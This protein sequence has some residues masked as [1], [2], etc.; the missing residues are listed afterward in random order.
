MNTNE[1]YLSDKAVMNILKALTTEV[2]IHG[3]DESELVM[4]SELSDSQKQT[5][6]KANTFLS[7]FGGLLMHIIDTKNV[8]F[9]RAVLN[10]WASKPIQELARLAFSEELADVHNRVTQQ[11]DELEKFINK[12]DN[13]EL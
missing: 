12:G 1:T 9:A 13:N 3:S 5:V 4:E 8:P 7:V 6:M 2:V 11:I 10:V